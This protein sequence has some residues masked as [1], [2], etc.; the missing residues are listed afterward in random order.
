MKT[1]KFTLAILVIAL[2]AYN[3]AAPASFYAPLSLLLL[4]GLLVILG[5]EELQKDRKSGLG[6]T[7]QVTAVFCLAAAIYTLLGN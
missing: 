2:S 5:T 4:S 6:Y 3:L 7:I 1:L